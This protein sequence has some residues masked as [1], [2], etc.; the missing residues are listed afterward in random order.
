MS[1]TQ[2]SYQHPRVGVGVVLRQDK[3]LVLLGKRR[4]S[5]G[6][7]EWAF[8]GGKPELWESPEEGGAR[9]LLE[10]CGLVGRDYKQLPYWTND[11][12]PEWGR[13]FITL[14]LQAWS[15]GGQPQLLEPDKCAE[16]RWF[17]WGSL[18]TTEEPLFPGVRALA[19][20]VPELG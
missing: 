18:L 9:E 15:L 3:D 1:T 6:A 14:Y 19:L 20:A 7:G 13:H 10:E 16:W 2:E 8:P 11:M 4:G 12:F 5:H 17:S